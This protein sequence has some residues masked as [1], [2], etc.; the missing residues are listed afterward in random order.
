MTEQLENAR[1]ELGAVSSMAQIVA[2]IKGVEAR[3]ERK[4]RHWRELSR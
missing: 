3:C 4:V 1:A 2:E